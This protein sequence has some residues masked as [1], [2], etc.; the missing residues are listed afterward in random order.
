MTGY[1][2]RMGPQADEHCG[3]KP[4]GLLGPVK[5]GE[6]GAHN[7]SSTDGSS[8]G[9]EVA[10]RAGLSGNSGDPIWSHRVLQ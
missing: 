2:G 5:V 6:Q 7:H 8:G 10:R 9:P 3:G 4:I 1:D